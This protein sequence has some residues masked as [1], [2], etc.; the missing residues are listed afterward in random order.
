MPWK[1]LASMGAYIFTWLI[2]YSGMMG[3]IAGIIICDYWVLRRQRLDLAGLFNP[4]G[5]YRY[6]NGF[7]WRAIMALAIAIAP[8]IPGF[9]RAATT[10][11]GVVAQPNLFDTLYT[12]AWFVTFAS[13]FIVYYLLMQGT[14][15]GD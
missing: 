1:L 6:T 10:P 13:G 4:R 9:L 7:N 8:V 14:S 3:A 5:P 12:Y 2:G 11:G 15:K